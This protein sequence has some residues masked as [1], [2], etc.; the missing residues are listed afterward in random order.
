MRMYH[1]LAQPLQLSPR[2]VDLGKGETQLRQ[3]QAQA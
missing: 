3:G 1:L 2:L